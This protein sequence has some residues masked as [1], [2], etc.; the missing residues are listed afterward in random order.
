MH[1]KKARSTVTDQ[2]EAERLQ[3]EL[4]IKREVELNDLRQILNTPQGVRF[5]KRILGDPFQQSYTGNSETFFREGIR[6]MS[7]KLVREIK[8]ANPQAAANIL[9]DLI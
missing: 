1:N 8:E 9:V 3:R 7:I 2:K 5:I 4:E 6:Y